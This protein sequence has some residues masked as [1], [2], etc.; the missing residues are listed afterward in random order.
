MGSIESSKGRPEASH[1]EDMVYANNHRDSFLS[2]RPC[3]R[4]LKLDRYGNPMIPQA[5]DSPVSLSLLFHTAIG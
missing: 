2:N 3:D 4:A 1:R 5:S